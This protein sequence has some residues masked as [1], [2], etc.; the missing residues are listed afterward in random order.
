MMKFFVI[1]PLFAFAGTLAGCGQPQTP[2]VSDAGE[3]QVATL[4]RNSNLIKDLRLHFGSFDVVGE[5]NDFN[6]NNCKMT[7]RLLNANINEQS[8]SPKSPS[9]GFWC[10]P[11]PFRED[12]IAPTTF[13]TEFP[14]DV[15]AKA[16]P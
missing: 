7:A 10:E 2:S 1:L 11:G 16:A 9:V 3:T 15:G 13:D 4:Y 14:T 6:I 8:T 5:A 12:G